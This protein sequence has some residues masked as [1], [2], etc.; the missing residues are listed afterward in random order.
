MHR[1][2]GIGSFLDSGGRR[3]SSPS[4]RDAR[5]SESVEHC[6]VLFGFLLEARRSGLRLAFRR[7]VR[8]AAFPRALCR[9]GTD[10]GVSGTQ[11]TCAAQT[12]GRYVVRRRHRFRDVHRSVGI[13]AVVARFCPQVR[14]S[15]ILPVWKSPYRRDWQA[16][17]Q[18]ARVHRD[19]GSLPIRKADRHTATKNRTCVSSKDSFASHRTIG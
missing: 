18:T 1:S 5:E 17:R 14:A 19:G 2:A 3:G 13:I 10:A 12:I 9:A 8:R 15:T 16:A 4:E 7:A 6:V 11:D